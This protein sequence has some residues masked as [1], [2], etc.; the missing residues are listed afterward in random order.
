MILTKG[1][2]VCSN[3]KVFA[4]CNTVT[5]LGS[6]PSGLIAMWSGAS[7]SIPNGWLLC[8]GNNNT[9]DL[10]NRFIVGAGSSYSVGNT[11]GSDTVSL[12][13]NQIPAHS[14]GFSLSAASAGAHTHGHTF[15]VSL[16]NLKTSSGGEHAHTLSGSNSATLN[17]DASEY[18]YW[19]YPGYRLVIGGE[20]YMDTDVDVN[21]NISGSTSSTGAHTH[22]I[23]GSASLTGSISS[24]G[25]HAHSVSG[26]ISNTGSGQSHENRPPYYALCFIMKE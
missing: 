14:H 12:N 6:I 26:S 24:D 13:T 2:I 9:P 18:A 8:D 25:A 23:T 7:D 20:G 1:L 19:Q 3:T 16:G 22:T 4:G 17:F 21:L 10:R 15:G 5:E 11:G